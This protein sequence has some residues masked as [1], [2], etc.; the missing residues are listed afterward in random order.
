[1]SVYVSVWVHGRSQNTADARAQH[2]HTMFAS[3]LVPRPHPAFRHLQF[4]NA[5]NFGIFELPR[6]ILRLLRRLECGALQPSLRYEHARTQRKVTVV[7][8][9]NTHTLRS[10]EQAFA[11]YMHAHSV[12]SLWYFRQTRIH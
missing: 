2:G 4:G 5:E 1:M 12:R 11:T 7:L 8:P 3:S 10:E 6:S 9:A